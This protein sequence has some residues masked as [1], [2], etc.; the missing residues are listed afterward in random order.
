[1][2]IATQR[3]KSFR[4]K[5]SETVNV[6]ESD[7][8]DSVPNK[9]TLPTKKNVPS[10]N[11]WDYSLIIYGER[12]IGKTTL[13]EQIPDNLMLEF[14]PGGRALDAYVTEIESYLH[15][16]GVVELFC[17][18]THKFKSSTIDTGGVAYE[19]AMDYGCL[20]HEIEHPGAEN[21]YGASW[22]K[23]RKM[24]TSPMRRLLN[25]GY[26]FVV[27]GHEQEKEIETRSGRKFV[28][29][30]PNF[31]K[32]ADEFFTSQIDNVFYYYYEDG[33]RWLQIEGDEYVTAGHRIKNHFLTPKGDR[34]HR[35]PMGKSAEEAFKN[36]MI[37]F[38]NKQKQPFTPA[39]FGE[40]K[41]QA[42]T[43]KKSFKKS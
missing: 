3:K 28:K 30:R 24:F 1:M 2:P 11:L 23:I 34:I 27:I 31:P 5:S 19:M 42:S 36:L 21:D 16:E 20:V 18:Q 29:M 43:R 22:A 8:P 7:A 35:I 17:E 37:A 41:P 40:A 32:Q 4:R 39:G 14:E 33:A 13:A 15:F 38:N 12:K 25:S 26:G 6:S 10:D 9:I